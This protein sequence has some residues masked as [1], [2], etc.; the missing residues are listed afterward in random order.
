VYLQGQGVKTKPIENVDNVVLILW[1]EDSE[2]N[3][4][5]F[6]QWVKRA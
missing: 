3:H 1:V 4:L 2:G 6:E 5:A